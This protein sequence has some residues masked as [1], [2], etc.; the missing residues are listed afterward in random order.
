M[1]NL[2][3]LGV[4]ELTGFD[5]ALLAG[6][7]GASSNLTDADTS[8]EPSRLGQP[9]WRSLGSWDFSVR[10][11]GEYLGFTAT[12][13]VKADS[14]GYETEFVGQLLSCG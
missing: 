4:D 8:L 5:L 9:D 2:D 13:G 14:V 6:I 7:S 10:L 3:I 12:G 11:T 1:A